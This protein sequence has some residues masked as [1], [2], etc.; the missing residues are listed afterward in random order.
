MPQSLEPE[1]MERLIR[2]N[3]TV[4]D[5]DLRLLA[6]SRAQGIKERIDAM[7]AVDPARVF[8]VEKDSLVPEDRPGAQR[9]RVEIRLR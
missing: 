4:T 2:E 7:R 3:I 5:S 1:E 6:Q 8:L 9:S